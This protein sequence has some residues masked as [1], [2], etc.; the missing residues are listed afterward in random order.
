MA[1]FFNWLGLAWLIAGLGAAIGL[2]NLGLLVQS[3]GQYFGTVACLV[4]VA[5]DIAY[6]LFAAKPRAA[7]SVGAFTA[8]SE[9]RSHWLLGPSVAGSL[10]FIP[11]WAAALVALVLGYIL[12]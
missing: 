4:I 8:N 6:R 11:A 12:G 2:Q 7:N 1:I 3:S 9:V 5:L 10:M